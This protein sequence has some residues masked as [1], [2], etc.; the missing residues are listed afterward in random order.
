VSVFVRESVSAPPSL[1]S[2]WGVGV[3]WKEMKDWYEKSGRRLIESMLLGSSKR[4]LS[5]GGGGA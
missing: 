4:V 5:H 2:G 3:F 1:G